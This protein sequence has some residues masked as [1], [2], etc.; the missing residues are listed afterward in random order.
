[1]KNIFLIT[2]CVFLPISIFAQNL[3]S[4]VRNPSRSTQD[5]VYVVGKGTGASIDEAKSKA[6]EDIER[7]LFSQTIKSEHVAFHVTLNDLDQDFFNTYGILIDNY[8][9]EAENG[10]DYIYYAYYS[11][12]RSNI[13][14]A[15]NLIYWYWPALQ[16][17]TMDQA[18]YLA[19]IQ[20]SWEIPRNVKVAVVNVASADSVLGEFILEEVTGYLSSG[21]NLL[22][23]RKSLES[24]RQEQKFQMTGDVDDKT[25]VSIGKFAGA[26]IVITGSITGSGTTRRLRFKALDVLTARILSQTSHNF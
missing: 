20:L 18:I 19:A 21:G 2:F 15:N 22:F 25:A 6:Y 9:T 8:Y 7:Q 12:A 14:L 23:D 3:P 1:M 16:K 11:M 10:K 24:I 17:G 5:M 26:D 4:W 13:D